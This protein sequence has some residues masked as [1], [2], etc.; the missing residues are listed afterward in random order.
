MVD[1]IREPKQQRAIEKKDRIIE[2]GFNLIC[3]NGYYNTNTAEIAKEA[4][5]ST[6]IVY[7][8]FKD[9][10]DILLEGLYKFGDNIFFPILTLDLS[11]YDIKNFDNDLTNLITSQ[12]KNHKLSQSA[13]EEITAM[14]HTDRNVAKYFY[15]KEFE[16]T[17][18]IKGLLVKNGYEDEQL[19]EKV[20]IIIGLIDNL[21]HEIIYHKHKNINYDVMTNITIDIIK[22]LFKK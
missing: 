7:Q 4:E 5:V 8:Y 19:L 11:N 17:E 14:I 13:H 6:G 20:H 15:D 16:V 12:I 1:N 18:K 9:K 3:K 2:A 22:N 21:C 10:N